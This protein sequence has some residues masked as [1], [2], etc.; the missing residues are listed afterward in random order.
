[1]KQLRSCLPL[2]AVEGV[3]LSS[4]PRFLN[5]SAGLFHCAVF[6]AN[7]SNKS[8][9]EGGSWVEVG[10]LE[11]MKVSKGVGEAEPPRPLRRSKLELEDEGFRVE[12]LEDKELRFSKSISSTSLFAGGSSTTSGY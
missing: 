4:A 9:E 1:M 12:A 11:A 6:E 2:S 7:G 8:F 5:R 10:L 3:K